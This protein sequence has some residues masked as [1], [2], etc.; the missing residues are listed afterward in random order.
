MNSCQ[1]IKHFKSVIASVDDMAFSL[2]LKDCTN[3]IHFIHHLHAKNVMISSI[4][5]S[6]FIRI[7]ARGCG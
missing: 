5:M 2:F 1:N 7:N 6:L 3:M 4:R